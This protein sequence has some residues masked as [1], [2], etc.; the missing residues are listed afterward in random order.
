MTRKGY[1][2][3]HKRKSPKPFTKKHL[4]NMSKASK[5]HKGRKFTEE[6]L[7]NARSEKNYN[8]GG[9]NTSYSGIHK[10]VARH[11]GQPRLCEKCGNEN[12]KR[13]EWAN[14]DHQY[15]RVLDDYMRLCCKCHQAYDKQNHLPKRKKL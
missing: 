12:Q 14:I 2:L 11:K 13:Y 1:K 8:W 15:R 7:N 5:G 4:E 6:Q 10:W 3:P 9:D